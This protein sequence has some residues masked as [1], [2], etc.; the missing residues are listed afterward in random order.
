MKPE[1]TTPTTE[2]IHVLQSRAWGQFKSRFGW[3]AERIQ[4][5]A[6]M[7][8]VLFRRLPLG[9]TVGYIPKG[10]GVDWRDTAALTALMEAIH[11]TARQH[12]AVF[13]KVEPHLWQQTQPDLCVHVRQTLA[14]MGFLEAATIQPQTTLLIDLTGSSADVLA[15]MKQKTRYNIRLG[16][17]KGV[18]VRQGTEADLPAFYQLTQVTA[19]RNAFD[20]HSLAYYE[21]AY[22]LFEASQRALFIAAY[23]G[24][25]LAAVMA[26]RQGREAYYFYGASSDAHR[27]L[28]A[29]YAVQ[30]AAIAWAI[31]HG[32][33][34]YDLWGIPDADV[35]TLEAE[36]QN[37]HDGLWGV[38]RFK[39]GFGGLYV[40]SVGAFDYVY[41]RPLYHLYK[42][43]QRWR[44]R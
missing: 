40:Q 17:K 13:L 27:A 4:H 29:P 5:G 6:A 19:T 16:P 25:P 18:T 10:P 43:Y 38:Y 32:C 1:H 2:D 28:M 23:E 21:A 8:Q 34:Q 42:L 24:D 7:A 37:R 12:R 35:A 9:F 20:V 39:R 44:R 14:Q 15:R 30:W 36:F 11:A 41:H 22:Q 31:H 26:F 33:T 3:T